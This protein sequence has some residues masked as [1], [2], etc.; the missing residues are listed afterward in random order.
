MLSENISLRFGSSSG[1]RSHHQDV[2]TLFKTKD[3]AAFYSFVRQDLDALDESALDLPPGKSFKRGARAAI[4]LTGEFGFLGYAIRQAQSILRIDK[5][6]SYWS[7]CFLLHDVLPA[8]PQIIRGKGPESPILW[9][10][11]ID[12]SGPLRHLHMVNGVSPRPLHDYNTAKYDP[13]K[14]HCV[15]NVALIVFALDESEI[16]AIL[17][18]ATHPQVDSLRYDFSGLLG[19]WLSYLFRRENEQNPLGAGHAVYCSAF[20]QLAYDSVSIDLASGAHT[21][22]TSPEHI[23]QS[24]L[25][26][27]ETFR[28]HGHPVRVY[29]CIREGACVSMPADARMNLSLEHATSL[30]RGK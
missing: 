22:N 21:R 1:D 6:P 28:R 16:D 25:W 24:A 23:W 4:G 20:C 5:Q 18:R 8:D 11:T 3:N 10:S 29:S 2:S 19:T 17:A 30:I 27:A 12:I 14:P 26:F 7:H 9:E 13:L 15:P